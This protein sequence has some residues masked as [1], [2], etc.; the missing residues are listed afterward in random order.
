MVNPLGGDMGMRTVSQPPRSRAL[1]REFTSEISPPMPRSPVPS[2]QVPRRQLATLA[3]LALGTLFVSACADKVVA[4][5]TSD[6]VR[7]SVTP[8]SRTLGVGETVVPTVVA[9]KCGGMVDT[10]FLGDWVARD[11]LVATVDSRTGR[12]TARQAGQTQIVAR[13]FDRPDA[14]TFSADSMA[15]IVR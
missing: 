6:P 2:A 1:K 9:R 11:T 14:P 13:Y 4:V 8:S 7:L 12:T 3:G 15:L 5:C 10:P